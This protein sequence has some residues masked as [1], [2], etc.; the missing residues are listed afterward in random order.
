MLKPDILFVLC[1]NASI[2]GARHIIQIL[3]FLNYPHFSKDKATTV[4]EYMQIYNC[5]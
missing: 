1:S 3:S 4:L 2:S 5:L